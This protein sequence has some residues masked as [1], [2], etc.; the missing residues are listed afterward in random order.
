[1]LRSLRLSILAIFSLSIAAGCSSK[2]DDPTDTSSESA[3][4]GGWTKMLTC[5]QGDSRV[6]VDVDSGERRN[7]QVVISG[8]AAYWLASNYH[9]ST[10]PIL[11]SKGEVIGGGTVSRGIFYPSDFDIAQTR[12]PYMNLEAKRDNGGL[13]VALWVD[14]RGAQ[15][16]F[17]RGG[18]DPC[19]GSLCQCPGGPDD[20]YCPGDPHAEIANWYFPSCDH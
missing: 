18:G 15:G 1:M 11:N 4:V 5:T 10:T 17:C 3:L 7:V 13:R 16:C 9:Q 20:L 6:V 14:A 8:P 2:A 12:V 19:G